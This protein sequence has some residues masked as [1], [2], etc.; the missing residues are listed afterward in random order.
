MVC[1]CKC[2]NIL[3]DLKTYIKSSGERGNTSRKK[4][5]QTVIILWAHK[6]IT[7]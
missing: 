6:V 1:L 7:I 4:K 5:Q 2:K 3:I